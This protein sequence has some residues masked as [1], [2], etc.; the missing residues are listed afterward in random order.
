MIGAN[1]IGRKMIGMN[2]IGRNC[3]GRKM[4]GGHCIGGH[5][6]CWKMIGGHCIGA[7]IMWGK[8]MGGNA[9]LRSPPGS[10]GSVQSG[11]AQKKLTR[12][13]LDAL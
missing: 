12:K 4:I 8:I 1:R 2:W 11:G 13:G 9:A 3:I 6:V 7:N 5:C 10:R